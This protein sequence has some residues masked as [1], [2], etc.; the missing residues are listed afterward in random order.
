MAITI[1]ELKVQR[2]G[3]CN[4]G[5]SRHGKQS[6]EFYDS[7]FLCITFES[8]LLTFFTSNKWSYPKIEKK[9]Y[10]AL[11]KAGCKLAKPVKTSLW[12]VW[13]EQH[14]Q[15]GIKMR[16]N[17]PKLLDLLIFSIYSLNFSLEFL[18][19]ISFVKNQLNI[20]KFLPPQIR[21]TL[22]SY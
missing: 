15:P 6:C 5:V 3:F 9:V 1:M 13:A 11:A 16:T 18:I 12:V 10:M 2:Q 14:G 19:M 17:L 8:K 4:C 20:S 21:K 22:I 7:L